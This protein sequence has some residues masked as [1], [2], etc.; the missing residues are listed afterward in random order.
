M[1]TH[2]AAFTSN[3]IQPLT[4]QSGREVALAVKAAVQAFDPNA[5][6]VL[7]GSRARGTERQDSDF[8]FLILT[9]QPVDFQLKR[10]VLN[11]LY[12][13]ELRTGYVISALIEN[14]ND[15][16]LMVHSPI[17]GEI[18]KDGVTI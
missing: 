5:S 12:D 1:R 14:E 2:Q 8:Y 17:F 11:R 9:K 10:Q 13:V 4:R 6:V 15:W 16:Q 7:F 18:Q 3:S